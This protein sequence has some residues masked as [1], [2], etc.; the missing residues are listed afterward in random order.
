MEL[1]FDNSIVQAMMEN[2]MKQPAVEKH[3]DCGR[4]G[5][6]FMS[7]GSIYYVLDG[8]RIHAFHSEASVTD[9]EK[10]T[11]R[12]AKRMGVELLETDYGWSIESEYRERE[13]ILKQILVIRK[14]EPWF[15]TTVV[16]S[17][18][19]ATV[20]TNYLAPLDFI[21]PSVQCNPLFLSLDQRMLLVPYDNDMW[22]RYESAHLRP[23]RTSYDIT[24]IFDEKSFNGLIAG[25]LDFDCWKNA[26]RCAS[27]DARCYTAFSGVADAC[28]H[29]CAPHGTIEGDSVR[30]ARFLCGWVDDVRT[31]LEFYGSRAMEG[32][33]KFKWKHGVPFGWN[34]Y[35]AL[36]IGTTTEHW[37]EAA[38]FISNELPNFHSEE[39]ITFI[40][41]DATFG[42]SE[43]K[44]AKVIEICHARG[45]KVGTY[46]APLTMIPGTE[47][48]F[49]LK[50]SF[51]KKRDQTIMRLPDGTPYHAID[52]SIPVDI[53]RPEV[54]LDLR[55]TLRDIVAKGYDYLKFDFLSHGSVEGQ[56]F[57]KRVRTGR[58]ALS[59]FYRILVEEL[60]PE[61]IGRD[62]FISLSIA[63]LFPGG[64]G[65]ARRS[66]CDTFGHHEDVRYVLN[67]LNFGWWSSGSVYCYADPDH[68]VLYNSIVDGRGSTDFI[69]ARSRYNAS[70]I[71]GT[72]V[73]LSDNFGPQGN[74]DVISESRER[75]R[76][77]A[78]N[79]N[80]NEVA[81]I[82][83][84]FIPVY[85]GD[86]TTY[87]Y[88][89][90]HENRIF[91]A[92]FNFSN[93]RRTVSVPCSAINTITSGIA[94]SL[95]DG[96]IYGFTGNI[97]VNLDG[98]D[99]IILEIKQGA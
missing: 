10:L 3:C 74:E 32:K 58:Q 62:L 26:I 31:G 21:Y 49:P 12:S 92:L 78:N 11:T 14:G 13:F 43:E 56:R 8:Q 30:S 61:K 59:R 73:L 84:P 66:C 69:S 44:L 63:P 45:Q 68:T 37:A 52:G 93:V 81:R 77:L 67:A 38:D 80:L 39:G 20:E 41:L 33:F 36:A 90:K 82:G 47:L 17:S 86:G 1:D 46:L 9:G 88:S 27:F 91:V 94:Y 15:E 50:G 51:E 57:D 23:G 16:L 89:L 25:A 34:S 29:D 87:A 48:I 83:K 18:D 4:V 35:S 72:V 6:D 97:E 2:Y 75:A 24:A 95:N 64:Y 79:P 65:H 19:R 99:S 22:V 70:I 54:E 96:A 71:S 5:F 55:L 85:L 42:L 53:T 60:N 98:Y 76:Q 40:N 7:D 28:T